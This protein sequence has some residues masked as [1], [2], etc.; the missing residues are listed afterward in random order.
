ME[1]VNYMNEIYSAFDQLVDEFNVYKVET[2]GQVYM[3]ASGAPERTERHAPNVAN[4]SLCMID[5]VKEM[6]KYLGSDV[7]VRIGKFKF[8]RDKLVSNIGL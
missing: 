4:I 5:K 1:L 7:D 3:A 8:N 6:S 2:V